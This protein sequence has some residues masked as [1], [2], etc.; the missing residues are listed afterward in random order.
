MKSRV[1]RRWLVVLFGLV[2]SPVLAQTSEPAAAAGDAEARDTA[3]TASQGPMVGV[4]RSMVASEPPVIHYDLSGPR[5]GVTF[6]PHGVAPR[7]QFG[8]HF[9][10]QAAPGT[11]GPWFL[12]EKI[13]LIG[14]VERNE[15]IPS[16]TLIFGF[17]TP[18][19]FEF[20]IG[21]S[22]TIGP[23]MATT[24]VVVAAGQ[25]LK[26]GGIRVPVNVAVAMAQHDHETAYRVTLITGWAISQPQY[27][28]S[29]SRYRQARPL[30]SGAPG[31]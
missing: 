22:V 1:V 8:W 15:F 4:P 10:N 24:A 17:R 29:Y 13:F 20:G 5:I 25:T 23:Q 11:R 16:G 7:S 30:G 6:M 2:A 14:G 27:E 31:Q 9:E 28:S 21:P 12:V 19:S 26:Y 18:S 3:V